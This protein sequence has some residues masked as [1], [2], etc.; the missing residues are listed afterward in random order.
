M[1][2]ESKSGELNLELSPDESLE[3]TYMKDVQVDDSTKSYQIDGHKI[4]I[5]LKQFDQGRRKVNFQFMANKKMNFT[6]DNT[7]IVIKIPKNIQTV[8][9]RTVSGDVK[10][11]SLSLK[12]LNVVSVS[13]NLRL[14]DSKIEK[15][16]HI[17]VSGDFDINGTVDNV[18]SKTVSGDLEFNLK[19]TSPQVEFEST[20]SEEHTS[21]L[22]SR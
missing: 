13:G 12:E 22:Q 17:S 4:T 15:I 5:D 16:D 20:R 10:I 14:E 19:N 9:V 6:V 8:T 18:K 11:D 7:N 21:E 2:I 3:V 1:V